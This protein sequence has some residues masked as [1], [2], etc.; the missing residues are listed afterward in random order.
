MVQA[1]SLPILAFEYMVAASE[2]DC[3]SVS[4]KLASFFPE[5]RS[6]AQA[7]LKTSVAKPH[8]AKLQ[9]LCIESAKA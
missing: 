6:L 4:A 8:T 1:P 3:G 2:P 7:F 5:I 9:M